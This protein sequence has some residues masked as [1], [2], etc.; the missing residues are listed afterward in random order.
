MRIAQHTHK[1]AKVEQEKAVPFKDLAKHSV[2]SGSLLLW[3]LCEADYVNTPRAFGPSSI[4]PSLCRV[5]VSGV[6]G[7]GCRHR[8][9]LPSLGGG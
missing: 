3:P 2:H 1:D 8:G 7:N 5:A 4:V 9:P 6:S